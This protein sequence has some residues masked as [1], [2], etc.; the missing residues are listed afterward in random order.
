MLVLTPI[1]N[2]QGQAQLNASF[3]QGD[4]IP[5]NFKIDNAGIPLNLLGM[6]VK[7]TIGFA[8]PLLLS[9]GNGK[10]QIIDAVGGEFQV[11]LSSAE[12]ALFVP[13]VYDYD[14]WIEESFSPPVER[15]YLTGKITVNPSVSTYP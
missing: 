1:L 14:L 7:M 8:T 13:G 10:I 6:L 15:Q 11:N 2:P 3:T 9:T 4:I 12:T 5:W